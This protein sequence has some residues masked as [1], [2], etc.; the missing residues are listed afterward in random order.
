[1]NLNNNN[2]FDPL[3]LEKKIIGKE[4]LSYYERLKEILKAKQI[5][6]ETG[7]LSSCVR[8]EV[9]QSWQR[10]IETLDPKGTI[11][12]LSE[13]DTRDLLEK[14]KHLIR[15]ASYVLDFINNNFKEPHYIMYVTDRDGYI[16]YVS[17]YSK[18]NI[19]RY[20]IKPGACFG[21]AFAGT[22]SISLSLTQG[23][24]MTVHGSEHFFIYQHNTT[25]ATSVIRNLKNEL[26]GTITLTFNLDMYSSL[27][28]T[29]SAMAARMIER[30]M[31]KY[32]FSDLVEF[33]VNNSF[34][35][36]L[37]LNSN[38]DIVIANNKFLDFLN[39]IESDLS[40]I[41]VKRMFP[42]IDFSNL[43]NLCYL[44]L[45]EVTLFYKDKNF[46]VN[47]HSHTTLNDDNP[48]YIILFFHETRS[49]INIPRKF[50]GKDRYYTF[51]N[52]LTTNPRMLKLI[53]DAKRVANL[54]VPL[55]ITGESGTGKELFAQSIHSFSNRSDK[56]FV[57]VNCA[58]LPSNLIESEL[59]GYEKG[60]FTGAQMSGKPGMFELAD[61]GTIFLDEI[62]EMPLDIQAK[63]LRILDDFKVSRVGGLR[64]KH[65][66]VR[67]IAATNKDLYQAV[68]NNNFRRDLY[69]RLNVL[70]IHIPPLAERKDDIKILCDFFLESLNSKHP[71]PQRKFISERTIEEL[72]AYDW[73]GNVRELLNELTK[74]YYLSSSKSISS[75][76]FPF[77]AKSDSKKVKMLSEDFISKTDEQIVIENALDKSSGKVALASQ[78]LNIPVSTLYRK[79][80]KYNIKKHKSIGKDMTKQ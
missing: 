3:E 72:S 40:G 65:L 25:C 10:S 53:D 55:L 8:P 42:D 35:C 16:V 77:S 41:D 56:P 70:N 14:N 27:L 29:I 48:D 32:S 34:Q 1:M 13:E 6:L 46:Q 78:L 69:Y 17:D 71:I 7:E 33:T 79:I 47:F 76:Y 28:S 12:F 37:V 18:E 11:P 80:A 54:D 62:G 39:I 15:C 38:F 51:D 23:R 60:A 19:A 2:S 20:A 61:E 22:N 67:V 26:I 36:I 9:A 66:N 30:E 49:I 73:P 75:L 21:E 64:L 24:D 31:I 63:L 52:I 68:V 58:A 45:S 50:N 74:S 5:F 43:K 57:P 4:H 59:F 44:K